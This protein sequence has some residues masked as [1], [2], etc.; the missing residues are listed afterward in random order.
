MV[1]RKVC[2]VR[3][4]F[5]ERRYRACTFEVS[6]RDDESIMVVLRRLNKQSKKTILMETR[7]LSAGK[8]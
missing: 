8:S 1:D 2:Y 4:R 6:I 5:F 3:G 7:G